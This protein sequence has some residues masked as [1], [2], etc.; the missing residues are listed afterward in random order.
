MKHKAK[1][2]I[3]GANFA[4]LAA[5]KRLGSSAEVVLIDPSPYFEFI[6]NI[7][8]LISA[9]KTPVDLRLDRAK[10]IEKMGHSWI[11]DK[12]LALDPENKQ[13]EL[14]DGKKLD[15]DVCIVTV[16]GINNF[17]GVKGAAKYAYTFKSV[18]DC[19]RI[20]QRIAELNQKGKPFSVVIAGGGSEGVEALGELLRY[21]QGKTAISIQLVEGQKRLLPSLSPKVSREVLRLSKS[22]NITFHFDLRIQ[23]LM[24]KS[25]KLSDGTRLA[26]DLCIWTGGVKPNPL[27]HESGLSGSPDTWA[28]VSPAL[29]SLQYA[30]IFLA[31]DAADLGS[32]DSKQAYFAMESGERAASNVLC[33]LAGQPLREF[34]M[35]NRPYL[36]SFGDLSCFLIWHDFVLAGLPLS[37]L[38][39]SVYRKTMIHMQTANACSSAYELFDQLAPGYVMNAA[40]LLES[41][42]QSPLDFIY[43]PP[44]RI[45]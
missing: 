29:Q 26:Y 18:D 28:S 12:V 11:Q 34:C 44:V 17:G 42:L 30:D 41:F 36:Y 15:Y 24:S 9:Q 2:L 23:E 6:P 10:L 22:F 20:G 8:E 1:I 3:I 38:K 16:G 5:A 27:L 14:S 40:S 31:G 39:E 35:I 45:L 43:D 25:V 13:L 4:G 33:H 7:H 19:H 32:I 37:I 21:R